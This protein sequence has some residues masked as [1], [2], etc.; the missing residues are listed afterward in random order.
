MAA[1][2]Y[3]DDGGSRFLRNAATMYI[4]QAGVLRKFENCIRQMLR[5]TGHSD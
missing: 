5:D 2:D 4:E 1:W 3:S